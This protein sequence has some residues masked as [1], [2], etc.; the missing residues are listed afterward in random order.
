VFV[1]NSAVSGSVVFATGSIVVVEMAPT[2]KSRL[3]AE[4]LVGAASKVF[5]AIICV[6]GIL[7]VS[8]CYGSVVEYL[9]LWSCCHLGFIFAKTLL[10][11]CGG[12]SESR[13][14]ATEREPTYFTRTHYFDQTNLATI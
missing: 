14:R 11:G 12:W 3:V 13:P 1:E 8:G 5:E 7:F 6:Y 2:A 10:G 9:K 4:M